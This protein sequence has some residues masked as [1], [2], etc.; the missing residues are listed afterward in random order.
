MMRRSLIFIALTCLLPLRAFGGGAHQTTLEGIPYRWEGPVVYN[1]DRGD[2]KPGVTAYS[3]DS[4]AQMVHDAFSTWQAALSNGVLQI[5]E[6]ASL[7]LTSD[8]SAGSD[9]NASNFG[10]YINS[11]KAVNPIVFDADGEIIDA[12]YG[13][14]SKFSLLAF[15]GFE[16]LNSDTAAVTKARAVFSGACIPDASGNTASKSGCGP[17]ALTLDE[18]QV[19]TMILH[20]LGHLLG[21]DHSQVNP[22]SYL[23]CKAD[24][25]CPVSVEEDLPT[26]FPMIVPG[27]QMQTLHRDD[28]AYFNRLYGNPSLDT[29]S[30]SGKI[31]ASDGKT[32]LRGVEVVARNVDSRFAE[33]DAISF[34]SGAE[35]PRLSASSKAREN[36]AGDCGNY[37]ITGLQEGESYQLCVQNILSQFQGGSGIEPVDPPDALVNTDCPQGLTVTCSC[38]GTDCDAFSGQD[39]V[40]TGFDGSADAQGNLTQDPAANAGGC[41]LVPPPPTEAW[42]RIKKAL[43]FAQRF[44]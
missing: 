34:V 38:N 36:C 37:E 11:P 4:V 14:C 2:L 27:A 12:I 39:I 30:V 44:Q 24:G 9:V 13:S 15:A 22:N 35:A 10:L 26:M 6:G 1:V 21:M 25:V 29:C 8:T 42:T 31:L 40:T 18:N 28:I 43:V 17:C 33:T 7:P 19:K 23:E 16:T 3:H 5:S 20:E 32:E 41:S